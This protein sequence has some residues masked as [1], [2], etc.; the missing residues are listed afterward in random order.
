MR[1]ERLDL[2]DLVSD[3]VADNEPLASRLDIQLEGSGSGPTE[4]AADPTELSRAINNLIVNALRHTRS[5]GAVRVTVDASG[6]AVLVSVRDQC[7]GIPEQDMDRLFEPG[8]RGTSA[9]TPGDAGAGLGLAISK[10]VVDAHGGEL[11]V[12]NTVE[13]CEFVIALPVFNSQSTGSGAV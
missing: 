5:D 2:S 3:L 1:V 9:R 8:W 6:A 4:V 12:R 7:G 10:R 11:S 13:G